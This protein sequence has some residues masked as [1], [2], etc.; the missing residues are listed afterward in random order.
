MALVHSPVTRS[1][2]H[3]SEWRNPE[4]RFLRIGVMLVRRKIVYE[5]QSCSL[6]V[7]REL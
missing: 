7:N 5:G 6:D 4:N 2:S 3:K 1:K